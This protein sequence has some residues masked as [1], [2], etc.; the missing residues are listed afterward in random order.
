MLSRGDFTFQSCLH[1]FLQAYERRA[2]VVRPGNEAKFW[3]DVTA[4]MMSEEERVG[5]RY[6]RHPPSYRSQK[7]SKFIMKLD[8]HASKSQVPMHD[9]VVRKDR[10]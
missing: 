1:Y 10:P 4:D 8:Q 6:V 9:S 7:R 2:C 3:V 5:D